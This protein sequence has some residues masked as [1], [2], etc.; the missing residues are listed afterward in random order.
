MR[1]QTCLYEDRF[2][3]IASPW[4]RNEASRASRAALSVAPAAPQA[5]RQDDEF[6]RIWLP[7]R[8]KLSRLRHC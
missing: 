4:C 2:R 8:T 5:A 7:E 1:R 3:R 6:H